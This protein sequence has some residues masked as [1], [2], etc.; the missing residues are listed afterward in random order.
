[1]IPSIDERLASIVRALTDVVLPSLPPEAGLA[2]EQVHLAI[3]QLQIMRMQ[4]DAGPAFEAEELAD[5]M[6]IGAQLT[7]SYDGE[8]DALRSVLATAGNAR[9]PAAIRSA[10]IAIHDAVDS[11]IEQVGIDPAL[12]G[13]IIAAEKKRVVKERAWCAPFGFDIAPPTS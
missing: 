1:M 9:D 8:A 4:V 12:T 3:G 10:R 6:A 5:A 13:L 7:A 11:L 2:Q